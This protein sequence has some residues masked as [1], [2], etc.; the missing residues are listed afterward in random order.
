MVWTQNDNAPVVQLKENADLQKYIKNNVIEIPNTAH[1]KDSGEDTPSNTP[2]VTPKTE[3]PK[4][5]KGIVKDPSA[6]TK[7][8]G[9]KSDNRC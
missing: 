1:I 9:N 2:I 4:A 8:F 6:W 7:F 5:K 3:E